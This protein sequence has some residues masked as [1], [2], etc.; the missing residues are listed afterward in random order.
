MP[1]QPRDLKIG[2]SY[3]VT[4]RCNNRE[5]RL[6]RHECRQV[7]IY[8]LKKAI[9]KF[10]FKLYAL[11]IMS[12]HV[13][14]LLE[15]LQPEQ[16]PKIMHWINWY[17]AMCFNRMLNRSGHFWEKRYFSTGF[18]KD[19][20]QRAL[21]TLRYIHSNPKSAGMQNGFFYDF[22][23]YGIHDRLTDDGLTQWHP[24]FLSLGKTLD[25]CARKYRE[26]CKKYKAK[27]KPEKRYC[28]G[29]KFLPKLLKK[30]NKASPG[31]MK[32]PWATWEVV[33]SEVRQVAEKFVYA[34]CYD[35]KVAMQLFDDS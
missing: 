11:C 34:N 24:A 27:P 25:E 26:F 6:T 22:S 28:W 14:Y 30:K 1:R 10:N 16:L 33:D 32:L 13:H 31:Q 4:S 12:N 35:P 17:T 8:T 20:H 21:N 19:D 23:N 15:P 18:P 2:Y 3:H 5:F 9:D 29:E 7:F